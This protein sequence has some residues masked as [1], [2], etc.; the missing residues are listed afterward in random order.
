MNVIMVS[1]L[2]LQQ[3]A[4]LD[5]RYA[6]INKAWRSSGIPAAVLQTPDWESGWQVLHAWLKPHFIRTF[7]LKVWEDAAPYRP[8]AKTT[9]TEEVHIFSHMHS[10][11]EGHC[12]EHASL[13]EEGAH[14]I[15]GWWNA[16][17]P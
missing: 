12:A 9:W 17:S 3:T 6:A 14:A 2:P 4:D 1:M 7:S 16:R 15:I 5:A 10:P 11:V 8:R 13:E